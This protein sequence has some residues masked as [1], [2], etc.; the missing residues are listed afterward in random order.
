MAL[1]IQGFRRHCAGAVISWL[2]LRLKIKAVVDGDAATW[3]GY[4]HV[5][6]PIA[7]RIPFAPR[8]RLV[9][10]A[11]GD[12]PKKTCL[13][14]SLVQTGTALCSIF[15]VQWARYIIYLHDF[16]GDHL[17]QWPFQDP[18]LEVPTIYKAYVRE[19]PHKIWPYM[20][21]YLQF[22]ILEFPLTK[23]ACVKNLEHGEL[24]KGSL[25]QFLCY[26]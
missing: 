12:E 3:P 2:S 16:P 26:A 22:R 13:V 18:K 14:C 5:A 21:Q 1:T 15:Q 6:L 23:A 9:V 10:A 19:Y 20:V 4:A 7:R 11:G 24:P 25:H 8:F 17:N